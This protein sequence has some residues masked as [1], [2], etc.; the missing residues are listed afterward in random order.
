[1]K[2][3]MHGITDADS[4]AR[5][6]AAAG[7][8]SVVVRWASDARIV[9]EVGMD[10]WLCGSGFP[11]IRDDDS[12]KAVGLDGQPHVWFNSASPCA[13]EVREVSL[14]NYRRMAESDGVTGI[15]I[16]G[17]RFASPA[18]GSEAFLTDFSPHAERRAEEL[19]FDFTSMRRDLGH[20]WSVLQRAFSPPAGRPTA[21]SGVPI[22]RVVEA[23]GEYP[24]V[25]EWLRFRRTCVSEQ[26]RAIAEIVHGAGMQC[27]AYVFSPSIAPLV[28]QNY[29]ELAGIMDVVSPMVYR[30]YPKAPGIA[31]LNHEVAA[32][33]DALVPPDSESRPAV[34][35]ILDALGYRG[36]AV[37]PTAGS[38]RDGLSV[39]VVGLEC[40]RARAAL[41]TD[42]TLVPII[43]LDD[44]DLRGA[45]REVES[46]GS[47]AVNFFKFAED[48]ASCIG[49]ASAE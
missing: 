29:A 3:W 41:G 28:G 7:F 4:H 49:R 36:L 2:Y 33:I 6:L 30:I 46:S 14:E 25:L 13:Q 15:L 9:R 23:I 38:V 31:A 48:W 12:I 39:P 44:P 10:A 42:A 11:L 47:D 32:M 17:C 26:F 1:M 5:Q 19:G 43:Q 21:A 18:S 27:G 35:A 45:I 22:A 8:V 20:A 24:G 16:D 40:S 34:S 37:E